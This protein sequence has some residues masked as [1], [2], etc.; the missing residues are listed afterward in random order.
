[1]IYLVVI[2]ACLHHKTNLV[3]VIDT[4]GQKKCVVELSTGD[5]ITIESNLCKNYKEGDKIVFYGR[6]E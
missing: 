2:M 4:V 5:L 6:K 1:M 3:G